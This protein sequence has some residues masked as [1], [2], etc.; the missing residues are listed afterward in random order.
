ME[1][2]K[3]KTGQ[4]SIEKTISVPCKQR[5]K[6]YEA[7]LL[8]V[9]EKLKKFQYDY[10]KCKTA[11][12][13]NNLLESYVESIDG[14]I[15]SGVMADFNKCR[16]KLYE[17]KPANLSDF[18]NSEK[19][20]AKTINVKDKK[21]D[22][23]SYNNYFEWLIESKKENEIVGV[24]LFF[25]RNPRTQHAL[26]KLTSHFI[27]NIALLLKRL[28]K[29]WKVIETIFG[30]KIDSTLTKIETTGSD[31]HKGGKQVLILTFSTN[32]TH[33]KLVYKPSNI[34]VDC[35]L[36]GRITEL[37]EKQKTL[38][39]VDD[40]V[41]VETSI[42]EIFNS[43]SDR[44]K[45]PTYSF[46]PRKDEEKYGYI[47][48]L[49]NDKID[50]EVEKEEVKAFFETWG[51]HIS[52]ARLFSIADLHVQNVIVHRK[53]PYLIDLEDSFKKPFDS[54]G[55]TLIF[56]GNGAQGSLTGD[57]DPGGFLYLITNDKTGLMTVNSLMQTATSAKKSPELKNRIFLKNGDDP[58]ELGDYRKDIMYYFCYATVGFLTYLK[59]DTLSVIDKIKKCE[60]RYVAEPTSSLIANLSYFFGC[61]KCYEKIPSEQTKLVIEFNEEYNWDVDKDY[62]RWD[63]LPIFE[64]H[65]EK[66]NFRDYLNMDI[67]YYTHKLEEKDLFNSKGD[68]VKPLQNQENFFPDSGG[69]VV[70]KELSTKIFSKL[71]DDLKKQ[72]NI[73]DS[74]PLH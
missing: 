12:S 69:N 21:L 42:A 6:I 20:Y 25:K 40:I 70:I 51:A 74:I 29:D 64:L 56:G 54:I 34:V 38:L 66:N 55:N 62:T 7:S 43:K 16:P 52:L 50:K 65:T 71:I 58:I 22:E 39:Q 72:L 59:S 67:P 35:C 30:A 45:I 49:S 47:E 31:Y 26:N 14:Y 73:S 41:D 44:I 60:T 32:I 46:L 33:T 2:F 19:Q 53:K 28:I 57:H 5:A 36:V 4:G 13:D 37:S 17:K 15:A 10:P 63:N 27:N 61:D 18:F 3:F 24:E 9:Y 48:Y 1:E 23:L 68:I 11:L 8:E